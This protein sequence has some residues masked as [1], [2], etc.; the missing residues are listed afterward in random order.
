[1]LDN[2]LKETEL[3]FEE[4]SEWFSSL[5]K[6]DEVLQ[7][8]LTPAIVE[9]VSSIG[10]R[11][12]ACV[13][14]YHLGRKGILYFESPGKYCRAAHFP[15][16][17]KEQIELIKQKRQSKKENPMPTELEKEL[18]ISSEIAQLFESCQ[19]K[20]R[21]FAKD[22]FD[23]KYR[24]AAENDALKL[25]IE[26]L[27][28]QLKDLETRYQDRES[29]MSFLYTTLKN[30]QDNLRRERAHYL[31]ICDLKDEI[32]EENSNLKNQLE[33]IWK[34][35]DDAVDE[36]LKLAEENKQLKQKFD[37]L[38]SFLEPDHK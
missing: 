32:E 10:V 1:M 25:T 3:S 16:P 19:K 18:D 12:A 21:K 22:C 28:K 27:R 31:D 8:S 23:E 11:L 13:G 38:K 15:I 26:Q 6:G 24:L 20:V 29:H 7:Y 2:F 4:Y 14:L 34:I 30:E 17:S 5:K 33:H 35:K 36:S 9:E 37:Q